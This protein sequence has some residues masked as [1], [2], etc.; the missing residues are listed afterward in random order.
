MG[1]KMQLLASPQAIAGR[2]AREKE[3]PEEKAARNLR[4]RMRNYKMTVYEAEQLLASQDGGCA[5]CGRE[6]LLSEPYQANIDHSHKT[7][8][9]R[10]I[11]CAFCN[12]GIK[13]YKALRRLDSVVQAYLGEEED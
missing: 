3:T 12:K 6:V 11:L 5:I 2:K 13:Y 10:G 1:R 7:H 8:K 4:D 9:V